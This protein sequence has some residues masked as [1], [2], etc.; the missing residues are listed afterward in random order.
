[1]TVKELEDVLKRATE[2]NQY[3]DDMQVVFLDRDGKREIVRAEYRLD[4]EATTGVVY[5]C[6]VEE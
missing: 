6:G 2:S 1:M 3:N 5:L 4:L